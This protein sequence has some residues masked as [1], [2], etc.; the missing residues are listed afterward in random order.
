MYKKACKEALNFIRPMIIGKKYYGVIDIL[1]D[2][3]T[4]MVVNQNGD[5]ITTK[6]IAENIIKVIGNF[7][8]RDDV[9]F[10]F[11]GDGAKKEELCRYV[12]KNS[13][14][15]VVFI[16]Y[17]EKDQLIYSLNAADMHF[18]LNA[19]GIK[20]V[21]VPSKI[22]GILATNKPIFG[23]LEQGSEAWRIIEDSD[24][25]VLCEAGDYAGIES[26]LRDILENRMSFVVE[27]STGFEYMSNRFTQDRSI[28]MYKEAILKL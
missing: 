10:A 17:Q 25:G 20:G 24:C 3:G 12:E 16:P 4:I 9:V 27:H 26:K 8:D 1:N 21:S 2:I 28:N 22:Y 6:E 5:M 23:V 13:I 15:N 7:C 14:S 11:V 19:K 18:V